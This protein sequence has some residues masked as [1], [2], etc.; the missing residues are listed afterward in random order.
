MTNLIGKRVK[1][2]AGDFIG[3]AGIVIGDS[4]LQA[5]KINIRTDNN[6]TVIVSEKD[7]RVTSDELPSSQ[8]NDTF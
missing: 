8:S 3:F 7:V 6:M 5:G 2:I 1:V 4:R